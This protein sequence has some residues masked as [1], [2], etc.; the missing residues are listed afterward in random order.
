MG[1]NLRD[2]GPSYLTTKLPSF[3]KNINC[4]NTLVRTEMVDDCVI[5]QVDRGIHEW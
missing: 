1:S 2:R 5:M 4:G 3:K